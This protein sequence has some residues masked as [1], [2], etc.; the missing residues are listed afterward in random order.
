KGMKISQLAQAAGV[1]IPYLSSVELGRVKN[2]SYAVTEKIAGA[3]GIPVEEL[4]LPD[5]GKKK[6][7]NRPERAFAVD[8][9]R[10][11]AIRMKKK[12]SMNEVARRSGLSVSTISL[13][14]S[15]KRRGVGFDTISKLAKVYGCDVG[16]LL[17]SREF[18]VDVS[19][20]LLQSEVV[21]IG[22]EEIDIRDQMAKQR[23]IELLEIGKAWIKEANKDN[24]QSDKEK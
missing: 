2:P 15:G 10:L 6:Y 16:E 3:L 14:E 18:Y 12:L 11:R 7:D 22:G 24:K 8:L 17:L 1:S 21:I 4:L 5:T 9:N 20:L 23:V 13:L 19:A